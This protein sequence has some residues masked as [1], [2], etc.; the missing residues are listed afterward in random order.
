M[1]DGRVEADLAAYGLTGRV[2]RSESVEGSLRF[3][4]EIAFT[5]EAFSR[6]SGRGRYEVELTAQR[7]SHL[8]GVYRG[9]NNDVPLAGA[10]SAWWE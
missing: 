2:T 1:R 7:G 8:T 10:A 6:G 9:T 5:D 4:V 3:E